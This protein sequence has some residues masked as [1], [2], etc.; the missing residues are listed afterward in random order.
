MG[1][2]FTLLLYGMPLNKI[3]FSQSTHTFFTWNS[4][5]ILEGRWGQYSDCKVKERLEHQHEEEI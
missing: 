5:R 3:H 2:S 1:P 4:G